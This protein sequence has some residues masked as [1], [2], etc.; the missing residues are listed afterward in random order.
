MGL[1]RTPASMLA[2]AAFMAMA[3]SSLPHDGRIA[4]PPRYRPSEP[5]GPLPDPEALGKA[6]AKRSRRAAAF[7]AQMEK[8]KARP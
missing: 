2:L 1:Q 3:T 5:G 4:P 6:D 7:K 8:A